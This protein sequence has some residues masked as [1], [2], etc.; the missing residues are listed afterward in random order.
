MFEI[1]CKNCYR[2]SQLKEKERLPN[3]D[4][5]TIIDDSIMERGQKLERY[6]LI[7][8]CGNRLEFQQYEQAVCNECG[9]KYISQK[10]DGT[11]IIESVES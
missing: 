1:I 9:K 3:R 2:I 10:R 5:L 7:C 8:E 11:E 4:G 6:V